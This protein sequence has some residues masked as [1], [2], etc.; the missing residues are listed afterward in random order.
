ML[1]HKLK[2]KTRVIRLR[3]KRV[4]AKTTENGRRGHKKKGVNRTLCAEG[5]R[6]IIPRFSVYSH[7]ARQVVSLRAETR[8]DHGRMCIHTVCVCARA[9]VRAHEY[10]LL[11]ACTIRASTRVCVCEVYV[12]AGRG[13]LFSYL[14]TESFVQEETMGHTTRRMKHARSGAGR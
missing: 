12:Y 1:T 13:Y 3:L 14:Y 9:Y 8:K 10:V 5:T 11:C 6:A 7:V 2:F 4:S